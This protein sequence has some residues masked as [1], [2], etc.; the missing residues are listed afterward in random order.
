MNNRGD[1]DI[2][3]ADRNR[4]LGGLIH[5]PASIIR[6]GKMEKHKTGVYFHAVPIDPLTGTCSVDYEI[7]EGKGF[8]KIDMLN[9]SVY[10]LI[11]D[12]AHLL[13]MM[14][15]QLDWKV[16][17]DAL[18][19]SKLFHLGNYSDL[20]SRLKPRCIE[21]IAMILAMI[22]PGKKHLQDTCW[23]RG[24]DSIRDE[25]WRKSGNDAYYFKHAHGISYA[26][27]VYVHA[28]LLLENE[29]KDATM[30]A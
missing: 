30:V 10:D 4:A 15:R 8:F 22:R 19:V 5:I 7:A 16:F 29:N 11:R 18:F 1:I 12:E 20:C 26:M 24:F 3:F 9:V 13:E 27:L 23:R 14:H 21:H 2:D 28:N 17:E 6:N 25:I